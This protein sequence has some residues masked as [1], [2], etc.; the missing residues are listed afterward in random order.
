MNKEDV[1]QA[2]FNIVVKQGMHNCTI[3]KIADNL[4]CAKSSIYHHFK[5]KEELLN[6]VVELKLQQLEIC[7]DY[8]TSEEFLIGT[9][10]N[11]YNNS[12]I[13]VFFRKYSTSD[14]VSRANQ[15]KIKKEN[16]EK[17]IKKLR[18]YENVDP[19]LTDLQLQTLSLG[20]IFSFTMSKIYAKSTM[21]EKEI[22]AVAKRINLS[23]SK[24]KRGK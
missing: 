5:N 4:K 2:A 9:S 13:F 8:K 3:Q 15:K 10:K 18:S 6:Y 22:E 19:K 16:N 20:P 1:S 17:F 14:F 11:L 12:D 23:I 21:T 7:P 24:Q